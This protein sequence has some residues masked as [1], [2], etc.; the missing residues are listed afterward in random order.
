MMKVSISH[1]R[2]YLIDF[3]TAVQFPEGCPLT[4]RVSVD[5][6]ILE[7]YTRPHAPASAN[8]QFSFQFLVVFW[9]F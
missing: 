9:G 7:K 5:L 4:E 1:P 6:P 2:V 3:E 8:L